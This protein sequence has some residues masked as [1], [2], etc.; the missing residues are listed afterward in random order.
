MTPGHDIPARLARLR[1]VMVANEW[2]AVIASLPES[3]LYLSGALIHTQQL[4]RR[5]QCAVVAVREGTATLVVAEVELP[6]AR[7]MAGDMP[8]RTYNELTESACSVAAAI[9]RE[10][11]RVPATLAIER[12]YLPALDHD[13]LTAALPTTR[14]I[15]GDA[16]L[17]ALRR[18]KSPTELAELCAGAQTIDRAIDEAIRAARPGMREDALA[19]LV[20]ANIQR[21]GGAGVSLA[22]GM[23]AAGENLLVPHHHAGSRPLEEGD[24]VKVAGR[25]T[26][27]GYYAQLARMAVV[28]AAAP[29]FA[30]RYSRSREAHR[31]L[32]GALRPGVAAAQVYEEVISK[33]EGLQLAARLA[34]VGHSMGLE[35]MESPKL[36]P[37]SDELLEAGMVMQATTVTNDAVAGLI[38]IVDMV[39]IEAGGVRILS[40]VVD[41]TTPLVIGAASGPAASMPADAAPPKKMEKSNG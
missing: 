36:A 25:A 8:I 38:Q 31:F 2:D 22:S 23:V 35:Y 24:V 20:R 14:V 6:L 28:G 18:A 3:V 33:R 13:V 15:G 1:A 27:H 37:G 19:E 41:T 30:D 26:F 17:M 11:N 40:D 32:L 12:S 29:E 10:G 34:H 5:R 7:R 16:E 4:M 21:I 39:A 9:L